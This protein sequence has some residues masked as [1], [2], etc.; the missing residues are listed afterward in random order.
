MG[1]LSVPEYLET[2]MLLLAVCNL[3]DQLLLV[4]YASWSLRIFWGAKKMEKDHSESAVRIELYFL[5]L[6]FLFLLAP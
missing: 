3:Y 5:V 2:R 6:H 4:F 1:F